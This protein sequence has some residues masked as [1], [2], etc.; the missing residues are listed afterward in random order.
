MHIAGDP[1][2]A[3][4]V[5]RPDPG[6]L[7]MTAHEEIAMGFDAVPAGVLPDISPNDLMY[8]SDPNFYFYWGRSAVRAIWSVL[9]AVEKR[10][11]RAILGLPCGHGRVLRVLRAAFPTARLVA[12]DLD[13]DGVEFCAATFGAEPIY[14]HESPA[15]TRI[16][17]QFD[18]IWCGSL[19][20]HLDETRCR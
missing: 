4:D 17:D 13:T 2:A 9:A 8:R 15:R 6:W 3:P 10:D 20:T 7:H 12:C 14:A 1:S 19:F 16:D 5:R 11:V 18:L